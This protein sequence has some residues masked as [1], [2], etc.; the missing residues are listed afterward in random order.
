MGGSRGRAGRPVHWGQQSWGQ[1][2]GVIACSGLPGG[3]L[4][5]LPVAYVLFGSED[6]RK[7]FVFD[8][9]A[10][11]IGRGGAELCKTNDVRA[12]RIVNAPG[13]PTGPKGRLGE[14]TGVFLRLDNP[15]RSIE[16]D[17]FSREKSAQHYAAALAEF[18]GVQTVDDPIIVPR[19]PRREPPGFPVIPPPPSEG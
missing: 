4:M 19:P 14:R 17:W 13:G 6:Q 16:L 7:P 3:T 11:T 18:L 12:V 15:P 9:T 5:L 1:R 10:G 2:L 8:R